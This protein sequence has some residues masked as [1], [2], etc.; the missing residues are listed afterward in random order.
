MKQSYQIDVSF[1]AETGGVRL[2]FLEEPLKP[3][4][5]L[6]LVVSQTL[7]PKATAVLI[8][9]LAQELAPSLSDG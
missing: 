9:K 1:K 6:T 7:S 5:P 4:D 3:G 2:S 8:Q